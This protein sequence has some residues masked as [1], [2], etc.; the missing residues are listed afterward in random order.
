MSFKTDA[1][2]PATE[3]SLLDVFGPNISDEVKATNQRAAELSMDDMA[4]VMNPASTTDCI[5][6]DAATRYSTSI[7]RLVKLREQLGGD[8]DRES[9][10]YPLQQLTVFPASLGRTQYRLVP[11]TMLVR[12]F[13][14]SS[15][16][17]QTADLVRESIES[18]L[19]QGVDERSITVTIEYTDPRTGVPRTK[20]VNFSQKSEDESIRRHLFSTNIGHRAGLHYAKAKK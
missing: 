1:R 16:A 17:Q 5:T 18:L 11:A 14:I 10:G 8:S 3:P 7:E 19:P 15:K 13:A 20:N 6:N 9:T 2:I 12:P 4:K